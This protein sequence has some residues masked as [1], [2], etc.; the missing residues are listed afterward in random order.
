MQ[1]LEAGKG[2]RGTVWH[3]GWRGCGCAV[4]W[5]QLGKLGVR[6]LLCIHG[7]LTAAE[8]LAAVE[9]LLPRSGL[10]LW[11]LPRSGLPPWPLPAPCA[12]LGFTV[13]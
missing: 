10:P 8:R 9:V 2:S 11:P 5:R 6:E 13:L 7:G 3:G 4:Q 12:W 1:L